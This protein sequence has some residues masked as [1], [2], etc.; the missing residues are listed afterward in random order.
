MLRALKVNVHFGMVG[1]SV[2]SSLSACRVRLFLILQ[3]IALKYM[4]IREK[5]ILG[6]MDFIAK[7]TS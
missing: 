7:Q 3:I 2:E 4:Y 5:A 6:R 1:P